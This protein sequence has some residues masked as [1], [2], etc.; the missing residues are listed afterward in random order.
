VP[1]ADPAVYPDQLQCPYPGC[2]GALPEA[3]MKAEVI[4]CPKCRRLAARCPHGHS[5]RCP[6][7]N[8][9]LACHCRN[10]GQPLVM[11]WAQGRWALDLPAA[12]Q[13][14]DNGSARRTLVLEKEPHVVL[15]LKGWMQFR[16]RP[17]SWPLTLLEAAGRLWVGAPDGSYFSVDPF[18]MPRG[19]APVCG[20]PL[21]RE[22]PSVRLRARSAGPW[23][24]LYADRGIHVL[25]LL[26]VDD[27]RHREHYTTPLWSASAGERLASEPVLLRYSVEGLDQMGRLL[28]WM[29]HGP[30]G[31]SLWLAPL[32]LSADR[33]AKKRKW[34]LKVMGVRP[35][36]AGEHPAQVV[37]AEAPLGSRDALFVCTPQDLWLLEVPLPASDDQPRLQK[38]LSKPRFLINHQ[39]V[40]GLV[41]VRGAP[42]AEGEEP[43]GTLFVAH[44]DGEGPAAQDLL[45]IV[46][47]Q[48]SGLVE[49]FSG[50]DQ[51]G[52]PLDALPGAGERQVL[53][54][55][56]RTL[57]R[58]DAHGNQ[59]RILTSE[60]LVGTLRG[61][62]YQ[63]VAVC[64]GFDASPGQSHWVTMLIDL[65]ENARVTDGLLRT[66]SLEA[67]PVLLGDHFFT[68]EWLAGELCL[69]SRRLRQEKMTPPS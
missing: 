45:E 54:L 2:G 23:L 47:I 10:C 51:G 25:N 42:P 1:K 19:P 4:P 63:D 43:R 33:R 29:T 64:T 59:S 27:P 62:V 18:R 8:R 52:V 38:L 14:A 6:T 66:E 30:E 15:S 40:P 7:L 20:E 49:S 41:F 3:E 57:L 21:W 22:A 68:L 44:R 13:G 56:G 60:D 11:G 50:L 5:R 48:E 12:S 37:L 17:G 9:A 39:D 61:H 65:A 31:L 16:S 28:A 55:A 32:V 67:H 26:A 24:I 36:T 46:T 58:C 53:V 34:H 69:T 35:F